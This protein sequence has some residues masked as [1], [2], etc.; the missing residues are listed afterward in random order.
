[1]K[2][3]RK[4]LITKASLKGLKPR[5]LD[6]TLT[7]R[8]KMKLITTAMINVT[9]LQECQPTIDLYMIREAKIIK[10]MKLLISLVLQT[11]DKT[12][13][14]EEI[15]FIITLKAVIER[16]GP[17]KSRLTTRESMWMLISSFM[18]Q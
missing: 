17:S 18:K 7:N 10:K 5:N 11:P 6:Q 16:I 13:M 3:Q 8:C 15:K 1:M 9:S 14:Q 4:M 12:N 2:W